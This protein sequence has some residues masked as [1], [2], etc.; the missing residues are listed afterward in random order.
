MTMPLSLIL[1]TAAAN[2]L[3]QLLPLVLIFGIFYFLVILPMQKQKKEQQALLNGL[4]NGTTVVTQGGVIGTIE[5]IQDNVLTLR[6]RPDGVKM[7]ITR[8]A[9]ASLFEEGK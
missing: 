6:V 8:A 1:Q 4:T 7:Q 5:K 9:V 3:T 2:P